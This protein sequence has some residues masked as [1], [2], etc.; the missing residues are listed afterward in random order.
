MLDALVAAHP[1]AMTRRQLA[2]LTGD[3]ITSGTFGAY[4]GTL[5][6]NRLACLNRDEELASPTLLLGD[7]AA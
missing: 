3:A 4:L 6:P 1:E 5:R 7:W 2:E